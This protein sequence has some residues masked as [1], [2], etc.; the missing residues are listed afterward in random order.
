[1]FT[2]V[3]A[4]PKMKAFWDDICERVSSGSAT[5]EELLQY[6]TIGKALYLISQ[7][8]G[9]PKLKTQSVQSLSSRYGMIVWQ[10]Y[11]EEPSPDAKR[12]LWLYGPKKGYITILG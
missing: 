4:N 2:I 1:M 3:M 6:K 7:N 12:I 11:L 10:S 9:H 8:P 5:K